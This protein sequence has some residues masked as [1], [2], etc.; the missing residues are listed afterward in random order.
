MGEGNVGGEVHAEE[1]FPAAG[2]GADGDEL[3]GLELDDVVEVGPRGV[4]GVR[5]AAGFEL[6]DEAGP[7]VGDGE[8]DVGGGGASGGGLEVGHGVVEDLGGG[9]WLREGAQCGAAGGF[10]DGRSW[11]VS[12]T[13]SA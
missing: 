11:A 2:R 7:A 4:E 1:A 3:A 6:V 5:V 8:V 10:E 13:I 12:R 9:P